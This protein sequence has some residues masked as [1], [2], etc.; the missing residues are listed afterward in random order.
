MA[1]AIPRRYTDRG[2]YTDR[3]VPT[4][5]LSDIR[6]RSAALG[7]WIR[8]LDR[9]GERAVVATILAEAEATETADPR[10]VQELARWTSE[11]AN[12]DGLS[13][14]AAAPSWPAD[15]VSDVPLRD[16]TGHGQ[17]PR[18][19][20]DDA[21]PGVEHDTIVLLGTAVDDTASWLLAGRALG[22][23]LLRCAVD[24]VSAQPLGPAIDL[25]AGRA[26]LQRELAIVGHPQ[27]LLRVGFGAGQPGTRRKPVSAAQR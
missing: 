4:Q 20:G 11:Q 15:R 12:E 6:T 22:W 27:V 16:F 8:F 19:G 13:I 26:A 14:A 7:T 5:L 10:Y 3:P 2:P 17:H 18:A 21:P 24:G 23:L 1:A 9:P 25:P